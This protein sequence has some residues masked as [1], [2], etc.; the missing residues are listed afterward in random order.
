MFCIF[1]S[2]KQISIHKVSK[3]R[4]FGHRFRAP[5][6]HI[7]SFRKQYYIPQP[8]LQTSEKMQD[9]F[10]T[11]SRVGASECNCKNTR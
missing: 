2:A 6:H 11:K 5:P 10:S 4:I 8:I 9:I 7:H 3:S 1:V